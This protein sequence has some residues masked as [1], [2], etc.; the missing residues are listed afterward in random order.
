[1]IKLIETLREDVD[2]PWFDF[3]VRNA[4]K[5]TMISM[6]S[7]PALNLGGNEERFY[8][9]AVSDSWPNK[10]VST[11]SGNEGENWIEINAQASRRFVEGVV[12]GDLG[13]EIMRIAPAELAFTEGHTIG[14]ISRYEQPLRTVTI[15][16]VHPKAK[17]AQCHA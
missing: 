16:E 8:V 10:V 5:P 3:A 13:G 1:M 9:Q 12:A 15:I 7:S 17:G 4:R 11:V 14:W 6:S 2:T